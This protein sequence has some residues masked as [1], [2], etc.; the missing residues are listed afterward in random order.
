MSCGKNQT[1]QKTSGIV[2]ESH[3]FGHEAY[4]TVP[5]FF[6]SARNIM[7]W[8]RIGSVGL[9]VADVYARTHNGHTT[10]AN[11]RQTINQWTKGS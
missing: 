4:H 1:N 6:P 3:L 11:L 7:G 10:Q 9:E 5:M 2:G 8:Y